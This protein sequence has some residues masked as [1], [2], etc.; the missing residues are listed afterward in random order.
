MTLTWHQTSLPAAR[1]RTDDVFFH[2]ESLGWAVNSDGK[3]YRTVDGAEYWDQQHLFP[4]SYLR[5]VA[6][7]SPDVGWIGTLS[8]PHRL[9]RTSNGGETW[10]SVDNLPLDGPGR[11]CGLI[12]VSDDVVFAAGTNYPNEPAGVLRTTNGGASWDVL[13]LGEEPALLV[14][15]F[16][17][18]EE[19]GWVVGG[20]D[21]VR[22]PGRD[23]V[24]RDV[25]PAVYATTDGGGTWTNVIAGFAAQGQFPRGEWGWKIQRLNAQTLLVS[26]ENLLDGAIL[27]SDDLGASWTRLKINDRQRNANLEGIGFID[28]QRGWV[29]GWGDLFFQGGYTSETN[30]GGE[31][32]DDANHVGFRLNRFR[33]FGDPVH[34]G[35]ASGDT[36]YKLSEQP[37]PSAAAAIAARGPSELSGTDQIAIDFEVPPNAQNLE[38]LIWERFGRQVRRLLHEPAPEAGPRQEVWDFTA[39]DGTQVEPGSYIVRVVHDEDATSQV[40]HRTL[41][42]NS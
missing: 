35:Y 21:E 2:D 9:Y 6:F 5:C 32:W 39:D 17:S 4:D 1:S 20:V 29:G 42:T 24:R 26:L 11:I 18:D 38:I 40:V 23:T 13:D 12:A 19:V 41:P 31:S 27:R 36:V 8:G 3:V 15:I 22:H 34:V 25:I 16:F 10:T 28:G 30:D 33:F 14:D 7:S 37:A